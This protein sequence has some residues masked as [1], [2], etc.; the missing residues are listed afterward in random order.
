MSTDLQ[1]APAPT[2]IDVDAL[3]AAFRAPAHV[4][5]RVLP[6]DLAEV[7]ESVATPWT[8]A[9]RLTLALLV[10]LVIAAFALIAQSLI[11]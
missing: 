7:T 2:D 10:T 4:P 1:S 5:T 11:A 8:V 9:E 3:E 6:A